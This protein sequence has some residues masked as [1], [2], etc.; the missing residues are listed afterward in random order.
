[1]QSVAP[2]RL[3]DELKDMDMVLRISRCVFRILYYNID[4]RLSAYPVRIYFP[5]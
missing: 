2:I 5:L 4:S 3:L 1:M